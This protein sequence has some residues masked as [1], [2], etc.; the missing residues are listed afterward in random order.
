MPIYRI[1]RLNE[2][3]RRQFRWAPHASGAAEVKPK[4][5]AEG[6]AVEGTTPYAAWHRLRDTEAPLELGDLLEDQEGNLY[7]C[8]Y[9]G[10]EEARWK[11]SEASAPAAGVPQREA[12]CLPPAAGD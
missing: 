7:I 3:R 8:K 4:D 9:V 5:Y 6:G 11:L 10:F 12:A 2:K 1:Y